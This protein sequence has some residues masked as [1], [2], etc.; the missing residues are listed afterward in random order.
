[1]RVRPWWV[2]E[3]AASRLHPSSA[4]GEATSDQR[5]D[6]QMPAEDRLPSRLR[7]D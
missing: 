3:P 7:C 1:M 2:N 5:F 6:R 4:N